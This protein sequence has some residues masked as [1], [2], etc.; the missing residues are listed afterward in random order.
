MFKLFSNSQ[1]IT[2]TGKKK[3]LVPVSKSIFIQNNTSEPVLIFTEQSDRI[4]YC[5]LAG[6]VIE[7]ENIKKECYF[8]ADIKAKSLEKYEGL[9][10]LS[11]NVEVSPDIKIKQETTEE[12]N[13]VIYNT[14]GKKDIQQ[15]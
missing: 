8:Y 9:Y 4:P 11:Q 6:A 5:L 2:G 1:I 10:I 3:I 15:K 12:N 14:N 13:L 7:V